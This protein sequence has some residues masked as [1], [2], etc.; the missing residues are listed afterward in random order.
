MFAVHNFYFPKASSD[1]SSRN[2]HDRFYYVVDCAYAYSY[3]AGYDVDAELVFSSQV[4]DGL[5]DS[6]T[7]Q[8]SS[9]TPMVAWPSVV[10]VFLL[11]SYDSFNFVV[12]LL[13]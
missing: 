8:P 4:D 2:I 5:F 12:K 7:M 3:Y 1:D 9:V 11:A 10:S 13:A 6:C